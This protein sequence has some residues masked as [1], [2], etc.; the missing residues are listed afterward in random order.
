LPGTL[1][2]KAKVRLGLRPMPANLWWFI[3]VRARNE[4]GRFEPIMVRDYADQWFHHD[5]QQ[6][7]AKTFVERLA[8]PPG[9]Y[10]V[11]TG[12]R[13]DYRHPL[14]DGTVETGHD[15]IGSS[16]MMTVL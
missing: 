14:E 13:D 11:Y 6:V 15:A 7:E 8:M 10:Q 3:E 5:F 9:Q 16:V 1:L 2:I 4:Q 12:L